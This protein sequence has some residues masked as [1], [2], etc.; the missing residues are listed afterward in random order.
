MSVDDR[1]GDGKRGDDDAPNSVPP[2]SRMPIPPGGARPAS[3]APPVE[4]QGPAGLGKPPSA[5]PSTL[6]SMQKA[7]VALDKVKARLDALER[8]KTEPVAVVGMACRFPGGGT[9]PE[10]FFRFLLEGG[11]AVTQIPARALAGRSLGRGRR[12]PAAPR[13]A[14]GGVPPGSGRPVR[15]ALLRHLAARGRPA[16]P[17]AAAPARVAWE[18]LERAGQD[19]DRLAGSRPACSSASTTNDYLELCRADGPDDDDAYTATGNGARLRGRAALVRA[20]APGPE[21]RGGHGVL[22]VAGGGPPRLPE[23]A[24]RRGHAGPRRRRQ[25]DRSSPGTTRPRAGTRALAPDGPLQ[26]LRRRAPTASSAAR[27]AGWSCSSCSRTRSAT[28]TASWR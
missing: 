26:D 6:S 3:R 2:S 16:R 4:P 11:D 1:G 14:L 27:A 12:R 19:A 22:V 10:A 17:A 20:R 23:P 25:P 24:Q 7:I 8:Q 13:D 18:A 28:G 15:R 9:T 21:R 5:Q